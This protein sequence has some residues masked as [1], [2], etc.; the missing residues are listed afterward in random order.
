MADVVLLQGGKH[1]TPPDVAA[2]L[3][4]AVEWVIEQGVVAGMVSGETETGALTWA[5]A[6]ALHGFVRGHIADLHNEM[7]NPE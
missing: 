5:P 3:R 1:K 6:P 2:K 4:E 7:E